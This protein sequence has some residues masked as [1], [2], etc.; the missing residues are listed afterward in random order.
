MRLR[1]RQLTGT[2]E[3]LSSARAPALVLLV[4]DDPDAR[5]LAAHVLELGGYGV[6]E[7]Q[8]GRDAID[9]LV[10]Y[11]PDVVVLDLNMPVM[12]GWEFR[13][14]QLRLQDGRLSHIPVLL[15][16]GDERATTVAAKLKAAGVIKKPFDPQGLRRACLRIALESAPRSS[17][18]RVATE[19]RSKP[20]R[21]ISSS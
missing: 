1:T 6:V 9:R 21:R 12:D 3:G 8:N 11:A 17:V 7:A 16:T 18:P 13:A 4:D 20:Q 19:R 10:K 2:I 14:E 5:S 15:A